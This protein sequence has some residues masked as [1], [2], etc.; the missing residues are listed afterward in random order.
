MYPADTNVRCG[1][2]TL[3]LCQLYLRCLFVSHSSRYT[4]VE[5]LVDDW[6]DPS[7][8]AY[9]ATQYGIANCSGSEI[10][11]VLVDYYIVP[12]T[13]FPS[14]VPTSSVRASVKQHAGNLYT[15]E[16]SPNS[17]WPRCRFRRHSH[18]LFLVPETVTFHLNYQ[19]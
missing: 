5:Y 19:P 7:T 11:V 3:N 15:G 16:K 9:S 6:P 17:R 8:E 12:A 1:N 2:V 14:I 13:V 18:L 10:L 4:C